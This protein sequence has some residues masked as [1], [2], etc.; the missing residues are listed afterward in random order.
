MLSALQTGQSTNGLF[1][2]GRMGY[3]HPW[4]AAYGGVLVYR[5]CNRRI[6]DLVLVK[7]QVKALLA[8]SYN[9]V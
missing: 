8:A 3:A 7:V 1:K 9:F 4:G 2:A 5:L 6:G